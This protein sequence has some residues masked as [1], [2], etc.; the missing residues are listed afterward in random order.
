MAEG[1]K[2]GIKDVLQAQPEEALKEAAQRLADEKSLSI[3]TYG[4]T[5]V[6]KS[7]LVRDLLGPKAPRRPEVRSGTKSVTTETVNYNVDIGK[8]LFVNVYDTKGM[9]E[10]FKEKKI[11][12]LFTR[13]E[14]F[15]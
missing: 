6:G 15:V 12:R 4:E 10:L 11:K 2:V 8:D 3:F 9:F 5:G 7:S 13:W 1:G 14:T